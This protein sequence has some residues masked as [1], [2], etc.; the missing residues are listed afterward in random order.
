MEMNALDLI[1]LGRRLTKIGEQAMRGS[2]GG[3]VPTG[4]GVIVRDV[5]AHP[6]C[7]IGEIT[8]RS[9]LPQS[10]VS[11]SVARLCSRGLFT[12]K[13]D[14][15]DGRRTLVCV[16]AHHAGGVALKGSVSVDEALATALGETNARAAAVAIEALEA[17]ARRLE[18]PEPG[19]LLRQIRRAPE[20]Q[21]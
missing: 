20:G 16:S 2:E 3:G 4:V 15:A 9:G 1:L 7:S 5:F 18:P 14:P 21:S 13:T 17:V 12:T 19:P 11:Q 8:T 10:Y 6:G